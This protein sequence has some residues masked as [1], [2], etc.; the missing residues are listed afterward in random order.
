MNNFARVASCDI[1]GLNVIAP[2]GYYLGRTVRF[3]VPSGPDIVNWQIVKFYKEGGISHSLGWPDTWNVYY[4]GELVRK[5]K[6]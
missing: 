4:N 1:N 3:I 2:S 5:F 6:E